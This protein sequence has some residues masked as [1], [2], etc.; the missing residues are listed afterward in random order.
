M[1]KAVLILEVLPAAWASA[2]VKN[3]WSDLDLDDPESAKEARQWLADNS[4]L[5]V[6]YCDSEPYP[7]RYKG[8]IT[9]VSNYICGSKP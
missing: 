6:I 2:L 5:E 3:D 4:E 9:M 7:G 1:A 8:M